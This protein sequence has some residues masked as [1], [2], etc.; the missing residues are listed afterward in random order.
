MRLS[1]PIRE[2]EGGAPFFSFPFYVCLLI[3]L[4]ATRS[5]LCSPFS[6]FFYH[7]LF[8]EQSLYDSLFCFFP[9]NELQFIF[10]DIL[11]CFSSPRLAE[12]MGT[13]EEGKILVLLCCFFSFLKTNTRVQKQHNIQHNEKTLFFPHG[14]RR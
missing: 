10:R 6:R 2:K 4:F 1:T 3:C 7:F 9:Q 5:V 8:V 13:D 14:K 11:F 12:T